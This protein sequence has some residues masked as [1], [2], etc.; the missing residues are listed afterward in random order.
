[1]SAEWTR[2]S[3]VNPLHVFVIRDGVRLFLCDFWQRTW[4]QLISDF[5]FKFDNF[6][7]LSGIEWVWSKFPSSPPPMSSCL[8]QLINFCCGSRYKRTEPG[9][10]LTFLTSFTTSS[11]FFRIIHGSEGKMN[12]IYVAGDWVSTKWDCWVVAEVCTLITIY[13]LIYVL[14][15][16]LEHSSELNWNIKMILKTIWGVTGWFNETFTES[17]REMNPQWKQSL[18]A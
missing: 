3:S 10:F 17:S 13:N 8:I 5:S 9:A 14:V 18:A 16:R 15:I 4:N 1:M 7:N 6:S 2:G 12:H 11:W